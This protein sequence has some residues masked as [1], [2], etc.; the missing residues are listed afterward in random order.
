[1]VAA[2][3]LV[4]GSSTMFVYSAGHGVNGF[5]LDPNIGEFLLSHPNIR[6]P[7]VPKYY[8]ANQGYE[9]YWTDGIRR[10]TRWLQGEEGAARSLSLR[11]IG[12]MVADIHRTLLGGGVFYYPMDTK[13]PKKPHGKLRLLYEANPMAFVIEQAGGYASTGRG[14]L[15]DVEPRELHQRTP[16]FLGNRELVAKAEEFIAKYDR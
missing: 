8:S 16:L 2:G 14:P 13:D 11:Y 4:Y 3:Y 7:V 6:L 5:T 12:S 9:K 10:Y 1:M 15:R